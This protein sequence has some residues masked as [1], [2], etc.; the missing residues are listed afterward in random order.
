MVR[1]TRRNNTNNEQSRNPPPAR[2]R[3]ADLDI[4]LASLLNTTSS[5]ALPPIQNPLQST[6][7][8]PTNPSAFVPLLQQTFSTGIPSTAAPTTF[9]FPP[10]TAPSGFVPL[11][12]QPTIP[13]HSASLPQS[14]TM[15]PLVATLIQAVVGLVQTQQ[16]NLQQ[17]PAPSA[18]ESS[19]RVRERSINEFKKSAPPPF[20]GAT[21]PDEAE[22]W[23][24]EM[25]KAFTAMQCTDEEKV[26]FGTFMLQGR[27]NNWWESE[28]R[29]RG[30][31]L[32]AISWKDFRSAF[33][34]K[35]FPRSKL[36][37]LER[38][39]LD[40]KQGSMSVEEYEAEFDRL[41]QF[42]PKLV[43]DNES[44]AKRFEE[45]LN[46]Y[47]RTG[48]APL[49]LETYDEVVSRAKSLDSVWRQT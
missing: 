15:D 12:P 6:I 41:S 33:Y 27:A 43:D 21:N 30:S 26:R 32:S 1:P 34:A 8:P 14:A 18:A 28:L 25:E 35:Y 47:I 45:G 5:T 17:N 10:S 24:K 38:Q 49:H 16:Q 7:A 20:S 44:R 37:Q 39:F 2:S 48:L 46:G 4:T 13:T 11:P 9:S 19:S 29:T 3:D 40:L 22:N 31:N 36:R 23:I 42:A